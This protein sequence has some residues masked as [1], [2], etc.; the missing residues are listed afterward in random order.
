MG[1]KEERLKR[2]GTTI[3]MMAQIQEGGDVQRTL[4]V[5]CTCGEEKDGSGGRWAW[6]NGKAVGRVRRYEIILVQM[7]WFHKFEMRIGSKGKRN[8]D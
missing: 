2:R 4:K 3:L 5:R 7:F 1:R 8:T 6:E